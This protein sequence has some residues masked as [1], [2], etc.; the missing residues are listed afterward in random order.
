MQPHPTAHLIRDMQ[1]FYD[2]EEGTTNFMHPDAQFRFPIV[3]ARIYHEPGQGMREHRVVWATSVS[4]FA[5]NASRFPA[6]Q[7]GA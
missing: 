4:M 1:V 2:E 5:I 6:S 7:G 3:S